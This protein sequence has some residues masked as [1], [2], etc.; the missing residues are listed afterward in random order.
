MTRSVSKQV[1]A[2]PTTQCATNNYNRRKEKVLTVKG[3]SN[4][5]VVILIGYLPYIKGVLARVREETEE[6]NE[7][8]GG[9][10]TFWMDFPL[11]TTFLHISNENWALF[12]RLHLKLKTKCL[13]RCYEG[14]KR[15]L[16]LYFQNHNVENA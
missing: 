13:Q 8:V 12:T 14:L 10:K 5:R 6:E 16:F 4:L 7:G 3:E 11:R 9:R 1:A 15:N 2:N